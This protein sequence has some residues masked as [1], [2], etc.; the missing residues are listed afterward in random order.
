MAYSFTNSKGQIYHLHEV[1]SARCDKML[2]YFCKTQNNK[3]HN[4]ID[5]PETL[6]VIENPKTKLPC[7][8][9]KK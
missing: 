1:K 2:Y 4:M 6:E 5:L 8:R 9:R 3:G 7:V